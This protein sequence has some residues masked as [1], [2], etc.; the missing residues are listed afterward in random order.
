MKDIET[1]LGP[2]TILMN[3]KFLPEASLGPM[4]PF[5]IVPQS[6]TH[7]KAQLPKLDLQQNLVSWTTPLSRF[8]DW[9]VGHDHDTIG[10]LCHGKVRIKNRERKNRAKKRA[11]ASLRH[12]LQPKVIIILVVHESVTSPTSSPSTSCN[13]GSLC[14]SCRLSKKR[15]PG[16]QLFV[17]CEDSTVLPGS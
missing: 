12:S 14:F 13:I 17:V 16:S 9:T 2:A 6:L 1:Y 11:F 15:L 10:K 3:D 8:K 7:F 5:N 4:M